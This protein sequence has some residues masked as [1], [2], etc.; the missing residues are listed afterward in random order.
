MTYTNLSIKSWAVEDRPREKM[1]YNGSQSLSDAELL[2]IL[3]GSGNTE[4]SA[5]ELGRLLLSKSNND[6][7]QLGRLSVDELKQQVKGI[8]EAKAITIMAALELGRRR[9][10]ADVGDKKQITSSRDAYELLHVSMEDLPHE[11]VWVLYLNRANK[12]IEKRKLH[13]GGVAGT[14]MDVKIIL[15]EA[16]SRLAC[17][18]IIAHNHPSG[19]T[20][21]STEDTRITKRIKEAGDI[22]EVKLLDHLI[23]GEKQYYSFADEGQL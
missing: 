20:V 10:L 19:N 3:I 4:N 9:K 14:V 15:K 11:E 1:R 13:Q 23:I 22:I 5:V 8:G 17:A 21:P 16:L 18:M 12:V 2:A 6:L 7:Y